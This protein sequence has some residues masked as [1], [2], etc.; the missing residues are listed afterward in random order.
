MAD[1]KI[2]WTA[3]LKQHFWSYVD[4]RSPNECWPWKAGL[5]TQGYGQF[6]AGKRKVREYP[7]V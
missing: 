2:Q 5:F 7:Y 4:R 1:T 3:A 6:R